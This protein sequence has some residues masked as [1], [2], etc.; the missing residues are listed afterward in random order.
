M[1]SSFRSNDK[2]CHSE[3]MVVWG[4]VLLLERDVPLRDREVVR[5]DELRDLEVVFRRVGD[6]RRVDELRL[7]LLREREEVF[8]RVDLRF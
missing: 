4:A 3:K 5:R 2:S 7:E 6:F 1:I 8:F